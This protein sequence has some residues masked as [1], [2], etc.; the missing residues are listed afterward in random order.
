[1]TEDFYCV[2]PQSPVEIKTLVFVE[3]WVV[4]TWSSA[5]ND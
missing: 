3:Q 1:M 4:G 2:L 5:I